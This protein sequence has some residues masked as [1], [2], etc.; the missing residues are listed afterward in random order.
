MAFA[1]LGP[2]GFTGAYQFQD[3]TVHLNHRFYDTTTLNF[4]QPDPSRQELNNYA[5]AACDPINN[6]DPTGLNAVT[7]GCAAVS[8]AGVALLA[9]GSV[10]FMAGAG[11]AIG[12]L[13]GTG[14]ALQGSLVGAGIATAVGASSVATAAGN[15]ATLIG[16]ACAVAS[17]V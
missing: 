17:L 11:L 8:I 16:G 3:G 9:A 2:F 7:Y 12:A 14:A 4:T 15:A 5:Y 6:T 10:G 1:E 13:A